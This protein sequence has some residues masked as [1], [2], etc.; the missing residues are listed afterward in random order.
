M[1]CDLCLRVERLPLGA[2]SQFSG[3]GEISIWG[4][5]EV[6][7]AFQEHVS[8]L[9]AAPPPPPLPAPLSVRPGFVR[10]GQ[11]GRWAA[12]VLPEKSPSGLL[13]ESHLLG[14]ALGRR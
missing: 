3:V 10:R 7:P 13:T 11:L 2:G 5:R 4:G 14:T 6:P 1:G 12:S 8:L 9:D